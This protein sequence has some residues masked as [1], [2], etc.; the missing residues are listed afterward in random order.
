MH[1]KVTGNW[2]ELLK[3]LLLES[4]EENGVELK[5]VG[6]SC[7][8]KVD[9]EWTESACRGALPIIRV[10]GPY[11]SPNEVNSSTSD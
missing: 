1:I 2:T 3:E 4:C 11:G 5:R 8:M 7:V 6:D 10:D 9:A